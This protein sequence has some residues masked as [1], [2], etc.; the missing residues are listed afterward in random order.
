MMGSTYHRWVF[1]ESVCVLAALMDVGQTISEA[2]ED[3]RLL[4]HH[5][6]P[7]QAG[8]LSF[9]IWEFDGGMPA[10]QA[11]RIILDHTTTG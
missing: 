9:D 4:F 2:V 11:M 7:G 5:L 6:T 1:T 3:L 10:H 8:S